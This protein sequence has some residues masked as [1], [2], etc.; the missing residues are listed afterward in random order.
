M[1]YEYNKWRIKEFA[2]ATGKT[3][4]QLG[5]LAGI[6][7]LNNPKG[8]LEGKT[9]NVNT[10]VKFANGSGISLLEFFSEDGIPMSERYSQA[11]I[12]AHTDDISTIPLIEHVRE[13]SRMEKEH[14]AELMQKDIDLAK[15]EMEMS[16]RI[17]EKVKAEYNRDK[18][19]IIGSYESRLTERDN[20]IARLQQQLAEL[21]AQYKELESARSEK[22]YLGFGGVT[23]LAEKPYGSR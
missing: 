19:Q 21:T 22:G 2:E 1:S 18:E 10:L 4:Y 5:A 7:N 13:V 3:P 15:K 11:E 6:T 9:P 20:T 17:R 16:D 14:L 23:G 12:P 8:W